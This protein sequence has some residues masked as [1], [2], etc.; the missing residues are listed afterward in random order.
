[1]GLA[2]PCRLSALRTSP[3]LDPRSRSAF[4]PYRQLGRSPDRRLDRRFRRRLL[5]SPLSPS[6]PS[7]LFRGWSPS[8]RSPPSV[9]SVSALATCRRRRR[10]RC[11]G[12]GRRRLGRRPFNSVS[13]LATCRRRLSRG[14]VTVGRLG[15]RPLTPCLH[16]SARNASPSP[17]SRLSRFGRRRLRGRPFV[18]CQ[19]PQR[20]KTVSTVSPLIGSAF[21]CRRLFRSSRF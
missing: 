9:C 18:P 10:R 21:D 14:L 15:R 4:G 11:L 13:A 5:P 6:P 19:R 17:L 12:A 16:V 8:P 2:D 1:M 20:Q 7:S 3:S